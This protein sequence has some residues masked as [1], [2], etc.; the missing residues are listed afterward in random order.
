MQS[1]GRVFVDTCI[2]VYADDAADTQRRQQVRAWL[3]YLWKTRAGR[4]STQVLSE[5]YVCVTQRIQPGLAQGDA[6]AKLRRY[7]QWQPWVIDHQ[8]VESAWGLEVRLQL[9]YWQALMLASAMH[10]GCDAVLSDVL[11]LERYDQLEVI[12]PFLTQPPSP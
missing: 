7:Q 5:Y 2:L 11:P 10:S 3:A 8:T 6:R 12:N 9:D 1:V 4:I